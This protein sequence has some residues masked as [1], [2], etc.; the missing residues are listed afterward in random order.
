VKDDLG[1][2]MKRYEAA[3]DHVLPPN[4]PV[5]IRLDGKGF[6]E[7]TRGR[8]DAPFDPVFKEAMYS[9]AKNLLE[10]FSGALLGY[11]QSDE[12]TLLFENNSMDN[13]SP[14]YNNRIQKICSVFAST[15]AITFYNEIKSH[16][17]DIIPVFAFDCR[18]FVVPR[19][20]VINNFIWR[21]KDSNRNSLNSILYW[22]LKKN[23]CNSREA[24]D[25]A[26]GMKKN[27][28]L[29]LLKEMGID[30]DDRV[31]YPSHYLRGACIYRVE[32]E[33]EVESIVG[34]LMF[35]NL[36]IKGVVGEGQTTT[37]S[38]WE[39]DREIPFFWEDREYIERLLSSDD[40]DGKRID[41]E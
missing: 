11:V 32:R 28:R 26:N 8:F 23:G 25:R 36:L 17:D 31:K 29:E 20:E 18:C 19:E 5:I 37:R 38:S 33:M 14:F 34:Q 21:Q 1:D 30:I 35:Q 24:S 3:Q 39:V 27:E 41:R 6:H 9:S 7:F 22:T 2:R 40:R 10:S 12:M 13:K 4:F 16:V 15:C